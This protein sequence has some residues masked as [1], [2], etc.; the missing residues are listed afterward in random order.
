MEK[1]IEPEVEF[2]KIESEYIIMTSGLDNN[3]LPRVDF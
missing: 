2:I 3:E 1:Y